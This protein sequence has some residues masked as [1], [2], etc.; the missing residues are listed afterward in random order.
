MRNGTGVIKIVR[1]TNELLNL[2]SLFVSFVFLRILSLLLFFLRSSD[3]L[4]SLAVFGNTG[5]LYVCMRIRN[6]RLRKRLRCLHLKNVTNG[7]R[8]RFA[9]LL[10]RRVSV[11]TT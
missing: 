6:E 1:L 5:E 11:Y 8:I 4:L 2:V 10:A 3:L 9:C 7:S